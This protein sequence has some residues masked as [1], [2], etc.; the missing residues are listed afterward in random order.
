VKII[1]VDFETFFSD[2]HSLTKMLPMTYVTH[3]DTQII[4]CSIK[5]GSAE[6]EV[7]FGED[8]IRGRFDEL[9]SEIAEGMLLGHN[10]SGFDSMIAAWR[11]GLK[12]K[13]WGCTLAMAR[14]IH[15]AE[16]GGSLGKLVKHYGIGVK[17]NS[18]LMATKGRRLEDFTPEEV[19]QMAVYNRADTDQCYALFQQLKKHY[20]MDELWQID[21][22]IRQLVNPKFVLDVPRLEQAQREEEARKRATFNKV[23]DALGVFGDEADIEVGV[24]EA[25]GSTATVRKL[26]EGL[27]VDI[28]MKPSPSNPNKMIPALSKTDE[29][30]IALTESEDETVAAIARARLAVKSTILETRI[31]KFKEA[32]AATRGMLPIPINYCGAATTGRDS[33]WAYNPQ[34]IPS[35]DPSRPRISDGLRESMCAPLN[36]L[37]AVADLSGIELRVNHFLWRVPSSMALFQ[38]DPAKADLYKEF[39]SMLYITPKERITKAQRQ[40]GKVAHLGLG[41]GAGAVTFRKVAKTMGGVTLTLQEAEEV[42]AKWRA[43]YPE[44][45]QGWKTCHKALDAIAAGIEMDVDPWGLVKTC[46][47]GLRLP[48][49]RIIRYPGLRKIYRDNKWE[50]V[51]G[52]DETRI[53]AGKVDENIVQALARDI[54][55]EYKLRIFLKTGKRSA[56][57]VHDELVYIVKKDEAQPH[58]DTVHQIMRTPP[59]WWP[60]LVTWSEGGLG[61]TYGDAK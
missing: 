52:K 3:A 16:V 27:G 38:S 53:Y 22:T 61:E 29:G 5:V 49:G 10:M 43:A 45:V 59:S 12:P 35:V 21:A 20:T 44:I 32:A 51:Y 42:V 8:A 31:E 13:M 11:F 30:F 54:L 9:K 55:K 34:N 15:F 26:L 7:Y 23:A 36:H 6:T 19:V 14:P 33:G 57:D 2:S 18:V 24:R 1:T 25:L 56:L 28:P 37:V 41:F 58:I 50:W 40:V 4:S 17:D 47:E 46:A 60:Q 48:S 39:A